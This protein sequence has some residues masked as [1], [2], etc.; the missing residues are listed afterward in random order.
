MN[1]L[2]NSCNKGCEKFNFLIKLTFVLSFSIFLDFPCIAQDVDFQSSN[3]PI[4]VIDMGGQ[5]IP[6]DPKA[7][8]HMGIIY[9]GA[10]NRNNITDPF[11]EYDGAIGIELRG[12]SSLNWPK[13]PYGIETRHE[14][15]ENNNVSIC[16]M[17]E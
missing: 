12:T 8:A 1:G 10:E 14:D 17:P 5:A 13:K 16:G 4:V 7:T 15:G 11:N 9:N 3:L 6:D 2:K